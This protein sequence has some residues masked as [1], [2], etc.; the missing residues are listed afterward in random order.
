MSFGK[1]NASYYP[2]WMVI[3]LPAK[4]RWIFSDACAKPVKKADEACDLGIFFH[5]WIHHLHNISTVSG[6]LAYSLTVELWSSFRWTVTNG[7]DSEGSDAAHL[8]PTHRTN[9]ERAVSYFDAIRN[10]RSCNKK[11]NKFSKGFGFYSESDDIRESVVA[12]IPSLDGGISDPDEFHVLAC[13]ARRAKPNGQSYEDVLVEIGTLEIIEGVASMLEHRLV[14]SIHADAKIETFDFAPYHLLSRFINHAIADADDSLTIACGIAALQHPDPP[15]GLSQ[16]VREVA[17]APARDRLS[18][19]ENFAKAFVK[20]SVENVRAHLANVDSLFPVDEPMAEALKWTN[21]SI[22]RRLDERLIDPF[23]EFQIVQRIADNPELILNQLA[24]RSCALLFL[25]GSEDEDPT[26]MAEMR[27]LRPA[28]EGADEEN[29]QYGR[30]KMWSALH[31]LHHH[32]RVGGI[33]SSDSVLA[34]APVSCPLYHVCDNPPRQADDP[35]CRIAP[36]RV[37][38]LADRSLCWYHDGA[39]ASRRG[40]IIDN[41][42][43]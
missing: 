3:R 15:I 40:P 43:C 29:F 19:A 26:L 1:Q 30:L 25:L 13:N 36:W 21:N 42:L 41:S 5:E 6:V 27:E 11:L 8:D 23:F 34:H 18:V 38:R 37:G 14:R 20:A 9:I 24:H 32:R 28:F 31:F 22:R 35:D 39:Y 16:V 17:I 4:Y 33:R 12:S 2:E 7:C 10:E